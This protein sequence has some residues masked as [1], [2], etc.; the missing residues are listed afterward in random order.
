MS[1]VSAARSARR[2]AWRKSFCKT[3]AFVL[4]KDLRQARLRAD[5][6]A[7]TKLMRLEK[8]LNESDWRISKAFSEMDFHSALVLNLATNQ[9]GKLEE[10]LSR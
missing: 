3:N 8:D 2:R 1:L 4:Q 9:S 5:L 7:E 6:A 10:S